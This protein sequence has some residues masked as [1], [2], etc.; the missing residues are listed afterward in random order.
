MQLGKALVGAIIGAAVG[1]GLLVAVYLMFGNRQECGWPFRSRSSPAWACGCWSSTAA[2]R[3]TCAV[4]S[5]MVL[6]LAAYFGGWVRR[7][8]RCATASG[9]CSRCRNRPCGRR[10]TPAE[11]E[12][13]GRRLTPN[14]R[15]RRRQPTQPNAGSATHATLPRRATADAPRPVLNVGFYLARGRRAR[16]A[17]SWAAA[18]ARRAGGTI[19]PSHRR[20]PDAERATHPDACT[21]PVR[22]CA[23]VLRFEST[24]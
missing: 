3:V 21:H 5:P 18:R 13:D 16:G 24:D 19:V 15:P 20:K 14:R 8:A 17:T 9:Q 6:A 2:M 1:I 22:R 10:K 12:A 11:A 7:R 23:N 4:R